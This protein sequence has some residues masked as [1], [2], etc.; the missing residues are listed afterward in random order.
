MAVIRWD[1]SLPQSL[2]INTV[3]SAQDGFASTPMDQGAARRRRRFSGV[4]TELRPPAFL[5]KL[6]S[7]EKDTLEDFYNDTLQNGALGFFWTS[8]NEPFA[9][10]GVGGAA[11]EPSYQFIYRPRFKGLRP[12]ATASLVTW[13][14]DW[15]F[16]M[17]AIGH[18][19][20]PDFV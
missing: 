16:F 6:T 15:A 12:D 3:I 13:V 20:Y 9:G 8:S 18:P 2:S 7:T 1:S 14:V 10:V 19:G 4:V 11:A 5:Q 17:H